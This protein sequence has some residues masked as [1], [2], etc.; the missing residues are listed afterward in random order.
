MIKGRVYVSY[1]YTYTHDKDIITKTPSAALFICLHNEDN[2]DYTSREQ[3]REPER[4]GGGKQTVKLLQ[5]S[6][7]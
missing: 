1:I 5:K 3:R 7:N 6:L 2:S 4:A